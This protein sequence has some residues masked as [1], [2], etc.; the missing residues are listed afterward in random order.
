MS[1]SQNMYNFPNRC[2][3]L[4]SNYFMNFKFLSGN[5]KLLLLIINIQ[6]IKKT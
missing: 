4:K 6:V 5:Y 3:S 1:R 2:V